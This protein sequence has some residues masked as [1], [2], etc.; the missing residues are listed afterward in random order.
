MTPPLA[1]FIAKLAAE[2]D[3]RTRERSLKRR[4]AGQ[5]W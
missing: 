1:E 4:G 3:K 2:R 5:E